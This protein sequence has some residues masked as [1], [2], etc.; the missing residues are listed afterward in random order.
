MKYKFTHFW[1]GSFWY[2]ADDGTV[3]EVYY[4]N[5]MDAE[6]NAQETEDDLKKDSDCFTQFK[7]GKE[8]DEGGW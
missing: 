5:P 1:K 8:I 7:D 3:I 4:W 6:L 2:S